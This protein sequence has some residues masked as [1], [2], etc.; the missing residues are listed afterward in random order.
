MRNLVIASAT[1]LALAC[2]HRQGASKPDAPPPAPAPPPVAQPNTV[3]TDEPIRADPRTLEQI[4]AGRISGVNV[5]PAPGGG[6]VV[7]FTQAMSFL[8]GAEPLFIVDGSPVSP[9]QG[10]TLSWL[11]PRDVESITAL[12]GGDAAIYGVRGANGVIII[13]TKGSH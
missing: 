7:R 9:G 2:S 13:K 4:L 11:N 8:A 10:G 12:K 5:T 6:I 1:A 3:S